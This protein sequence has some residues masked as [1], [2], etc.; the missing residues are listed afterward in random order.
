M[1]RKALIRENTR[2]GHLMMFKA[3]VIIVFLASLATYAIY[4]A[5][6]SSEAMTLGKTIKTTIGSVLLIIAV[7][8]LLVRML[9]D[10]E[11]SKYLTVLM[12]GLIMFLLV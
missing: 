11:V 4:F 5:G 7:T 8:Y 12:V 1:E 10:K 9:Q 6:L 3:I 2:N